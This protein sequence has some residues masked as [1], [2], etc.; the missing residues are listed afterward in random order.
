MHKLLQ[1]LTG[2]LG[3]VLLYM[4]F[5]LSESAEGKI[6]NRLEGLWVRVDDLSKVALTRQAAFLQQIS[7][8]LSSAFDRRFGTRLF[9]AEAA[10]TSICFSSVALGLFLSLLPGL[11]GSTDTTPS[12]VWDV[13]LVLFLVGLA[14]V[15]S[16]YLGFLWVPLLFAGDVLY[17]DRHAPDGHMTSH[18]LEIA[19][20]VMGGIASDVFFIA[21]SRWFL[22]RS[23]NISSAWRIASLLLFNA[24]LG[25][26]L[27][28]PLFLLIPAIREPLRAVLVA[29]GANSLASKVVVA[30]VFVG[31]SNILTA[32]IPLLFALLCLVAI[33]HLILWPALEAPIYSAQRYGLIRQ[34]K[35]LG[36]VALAC[37]LFAWPNSPLVGIITK[38]VHA[39]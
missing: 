5:F 2:L 11:T 17:Y 31:A 20:I 16:R 9:S 32:A 18:L 7:K 36:A 37:L 26:V 22:R 15:P 3:L 1:L 13:M 4:A 14:P 39:G 21:A 28:S 6:Q 10:A 30:L 8:L 35:L 27:V 29:G 23:E 24:C 34:P 12:G 25:L 38:L 19:G 33:A